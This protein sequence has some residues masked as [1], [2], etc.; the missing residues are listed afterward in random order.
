VQIGVS[1]S[2]SNGVP[3][4]LAVQDINCG[5]H[6][7]HVTAMQQSRRAKQRHFQETAAGQSSA[8]SAFMP[9]SAS[10]TGSRAE[11]GNVRGNGEVAVVAVDALVFGGIRADA[12]N[13]QGDEGVAVVAADVLALDS[14]RAEAGNER[15]DE[16][17]A[18]VA[19]D[20]LVLEGIR[21]DVDGELG[22]VA[23]I[24]AD[25]L[26]FKGNR[27]EAGNVCGDEGVAVVAADLFLLI[28][29]SSSD[30]ITSCRSSSVQQSTPAGSSG[31]GDE[32][33]QSS[34]MSK[35]AKLASWARSR[36]RGRFMTGSELRTS[37][38]PAKAFSICSDKWSNFPETSCQGGVA[39][40][41]DDGEDEQLDVH[42]HAPVF[43]LESVQMAQMLSLMPVRKLTSSHVCL[44]N[45]HVSS[46]RR[47]CLRRAL[48]LSPEAWLRKTP[49]A[50]CIVLTFRP[51]ME[52][53][54]RRAAR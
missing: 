44:R 22:G 3:A 31:K 16:G 29:E 35:T 28:W 9:L 12:G 4:D 39:G 45:E 51:A 6:P 43:S 25:V 27:A 48:C 10:P 24:A 41:H 26:V 30:F 23:A 47:S 7:V 49:R 11:A 34:K 2:S 18:V 33:E 52:A 15:G 54:P 8:K 53:A 5:M 14:I 38:R 40:G 1:M 17:V 42:G 19:A 13:E 50:P 46:S 37:A 32:E 36:T 20:A 21:A